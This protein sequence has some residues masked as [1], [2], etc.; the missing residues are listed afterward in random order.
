MSSYIVI[1]TR[2]RVKQ[3]LEELK[4]VDVIEKEWTSHQNAEWISPMHCREKM[5]FSITDFFSKCGEIQFP[6]DGCMMVVTKPQNGNIW[7]VVDMRRANTVIQQEKNLIR[8]PWNEGGNLFLKLNLK[9][10]YRQI[11]DSREITA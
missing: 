10:E 9:S 5:K 8:D 3:K 2:D 6:A 1:Y 4:R 11:E 7:I